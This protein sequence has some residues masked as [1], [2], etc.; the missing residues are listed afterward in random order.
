MR[1]HQIIQ[2]TRL[3]F[4]IIPNAINRKL[5]IAFGILAMP[6]ESSEKESL[7]EANSFNNA[8]KQF[9]PW[10]S[11]PLLPGGAHMMPVGDVSF[12][13]YVFADDNYA[14]FNS[15]G[16]ARHI[17][18]LIQLNPQI[19]AIQIGI[20]YWMDA[21]VAFQAF[22][23]WSD[24]QRSGG[25]GDT[26]LTLGFPILK[27]T[28]DLPAMK[29]GIGETFPTGRYERFTPSKAVVQST[30]QGSCL[31]ILSYRIAKLLFWNTP[32]PLNC[33]ATFTYTFP[34]TL[35][36]H[37]FN[38]YGGGFGTCGKVRPGNQFSI[39]LAFEWLFAKN[40][41]ILND[42]VCLYNNR[43]KFEG[44]PGI[45]LK[46]TPAIVEKKSNYQFS[47]SPA[48]EYNP[49]ARLK[50]I[51]GIWFTVAGRNAYNFI[52]GFVGVTYTWNAN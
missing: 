10:Y 49:N 3:V 42:F 38:Y 11:G 45:S 19:N 5:L 36:V 40:W 27:E 13:N 23:N 34:T 48:I 29:L 37:G 28:T 2:R 52:Q 12:Q 51:G 25:I 15:H 9:N 50:A 32:H 44:Y 21:S 18:D 33:R 14:K 46:G 43:S 41:V 8:K 26:T 31:T 17:P 22:A 30:G 7:Q 16:H 20:T 35:Q 6:L 24:G 4:G 47:L 39:T 1:I